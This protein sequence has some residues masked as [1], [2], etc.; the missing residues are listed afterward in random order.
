MIAKSE[1]ILKEATKLRLYFKKTTNDHKNRQAS[2]GLTDPGGTACK[3]SLLTNSSTASAVEMECQ[4]GLYHRG[5]WELEIVP[6]GEREWKITTTGGNSEEPSGRTAGGL[7]MGGPTT[8][9]QIKMKKSL[10]I[11]S[12]VTLHQQ[13]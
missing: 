13:M 11:L 9:R 4:S 5:G 2:C 1:Q 7:G 12:P 10:E 3:I 8:Q 6:D